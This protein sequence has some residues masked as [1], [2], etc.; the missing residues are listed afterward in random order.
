MCVERDRQTLLLGYLERSFQMPLSIRGNMALAVPMRGGTMFNRCAQLLSRWLVRNPSRCSWKSKQVFRARRSTFAHTQ[1]LTKA[2]ATPL[3][4]ASQ[5]T[6]Q[7]AIPT[8]TR[9]HGVK[10]STKW[11][12]FTG[13]SCQHGGRKERQTSVRRDG[14]DAL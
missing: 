5:A 1:M 11:M 14:L 3:G 7:D 4:L 9:I 12:L 10:K 8:C 13:S 6:K 2:R